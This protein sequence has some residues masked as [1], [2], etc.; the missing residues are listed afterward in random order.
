MLPAY[1]LIALI[2]PFTLQKL[3]W[4]KIRVS[5]AGIL[6][7]YFTVI[8]IQGTLLY[9]PEPGGSSLQR[10]ALCVAKQPGKEVALLVDE[11]QRKI[12]NVFETAQIGISS[13]FIYGGTPSF[14]YYSGKQVRFFYDTNNFLK[15]HRSYPL[16]MLSDG[17]AVNLFSGISLGEPVCQEDAWSAVA[18]R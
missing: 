8:G 14:V 18:A 11:E 17:D 7:A 4:Q 5:I 2:L 15:E 1:P 9:R 6:A 13:S 12:K 16:A 10:L 3:P